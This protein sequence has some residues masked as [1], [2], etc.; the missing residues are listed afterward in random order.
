MI[1]IIYSNENQEELKKDVA[2]KLPKNVRQVGDDD[3]SKKIYVEDYVMTYISKLW[4]MPIETAVI[5]V[6]LGNVKRTN[7]NTYLFVSGAIQVENAEKDGRKILFSDETWT[8]IYEDI[9]K[10]FNNLEIVG[11]FLAGGDTGIEIDESLFRTHVDNF[12][13]NDKALLLV[14]PIEKEEEF[15]LY[16]GGKLTKQKGY[17]I[18]YER[19][20][21]MQAY[22][23]ENKQVKKVE[24]LTQDR[25]PGNF[26]SIIQEK[27]EN[28][29]QKR[30]VAML[31]SACTFLA[32]VVLAIGITMMN[33]YDKMKSMEESLDTL[34]KNILKV[35]VEPKIENETAIVEADTEQVIIEVI[36]G[37]V[38]TTTQVP[39]I[40]QITTA[41]EETTGILETTTTA[42]I[43]PVT[44]PT[45][46]T[47]NEVSYHVVQPGE[48][49]I[50]ISIAVY[51]TDT[52]VD[53]IKTM[54]GIEDEDKIYAGQK[55]QLP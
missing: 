29:T 5:G 41:V 19:N 23:V 28:T 6:L 16:E 55:I 13:G 31:Y 12:A 10:H 22:M 37:N 1:E 53:E 17:Y 30:L 33:N 52:M 21:Q 48:S 35:N 3:G 34:T 7:G 11:W 45:A 50:A 25:I 32:V 14:D 15:Y 43:E 26:R 51:Q 40:E 54:N 49:L 36:E 18:Y 27:K 38:E 24:T 47:V 44:E 46:P 2:L 8:S 4:E 20:E 39:E 42:S 9:K